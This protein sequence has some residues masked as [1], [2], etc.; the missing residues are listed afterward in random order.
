M[1]ERRTLNCNALRSL[2]EGGNSVVSFES[3]VFNVFCCAR[4]C[5][6]FMVETSPFRTQVESLKTSHNTLSRNC[7]TCVASNDAKRIEMA[8]S[9]FLSPMRLA[10]SHSGNP[11]SPRLPS[12]SLGRR[13]RNPICTKIG[14]RP[15]YGPSPRFARR[16]KS[17]GRERQQY[18][19]ASTIWRALA[20]LREAELP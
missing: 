4:F 15:E 2:E 8:K 14:K 9:G 19:D 17:K 10:F 12:I 3:S 6:S 7:L 20:S 11:S 18:Q 16:G 13:G 1:A 5:A